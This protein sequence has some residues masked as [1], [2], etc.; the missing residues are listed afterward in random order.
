MWDILKARRQEGR[1]TLAL[2]L[3]CDL[4]CSLDWCGIGLLHLGSAFA[5]TKFGSHLV[6]YGKSKF[7][8][9]SKTG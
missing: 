4:G 3:Y 5:L 7:R 1:I 6:L 8:Y 9:V 2:P